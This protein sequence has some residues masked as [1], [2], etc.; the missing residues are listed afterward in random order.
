MF[1]TV[2]YREQ[3]RSCL[4]REDTTAWRRLLAVAIASGTLAITIGCRATSDD[5]SG[6]AG[7]SHVAGDRRESNIGGAY[8]GSAGPNIGPISNA[9]FLQN[10]QADATIGVWSTP[11]EPGICRFKLELDTL[12]LSGFHFTWGMPRDRISLVLGAGGGIRQ[13]PSIQVEQYQLC[14]LY[15]SQQCLE[16]TI[17]LRLALDGGANQRPEVFTA[18]N[19]DWPVMG[20][21]PCIPVK[22]WRVLPRGDQA[23][24]RRTQAP[25]GTLITYELYPGVGIAASTFNREMASLD[26]RTGLSPQLYWQVKACGRNTTLP[27][28]PVF[29]RESEKRPLRV[30]CQRTR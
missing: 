30:N 1:S 9:P 14:I 17:N 20:F 8:A 13:E 24:V 3:H 21:D 26:P 27:G 22:A 28:N 15:G 23:N 5:A 10:P 11:L 7:E 29:C 19:M 2:A 16:D 18:C 25:Q 12:P 6:A 4:V